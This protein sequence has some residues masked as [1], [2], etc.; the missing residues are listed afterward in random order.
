MLKEVKLSFIILIIIH[1]LNTPL[2]KAVPLLLFVIFLMV[3]YF[4]TLSL[5]ETSKAANE[6][7]CFRSVCP[8]DPLI[9]IYNQFVF[10]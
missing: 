8:F 5:N 9:L 10:N 7:T 6:Y 1:N 3:K 4:T 2:D